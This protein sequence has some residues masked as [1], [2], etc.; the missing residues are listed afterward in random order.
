MQGFQISYT[1]AA[2]G[3]VIAANRYL[4]QTPLGDVS[5]QVNTYGKKDTLDLDART[6]ISI[7]EELERFD[8][9]AL[10][11]T[12]EKSSRVM[13]WSIASMNGFN[14]PV[15][16]VADPTDRSAP[17]KK[18][19]SAMPEQSRPVASAVG[20]PEIC[21]QWEKSFSSPAVV[22]GACSAVTCLMNGQPICTAI[23]NYITQDLFVACAAGIRLFKLEAE[24]TESITLD[25][26]LREGDKIEF[27]A[28]VDRNVEQMRRFVTFLGKDGYKE[29]FLQSKLMSEAD[30]SKH[31]V[32]DLPGGPL[33]ILYLSNLFAN[34]QPMGFVLANGEKIGEWIHWLTCVHF[35]SLEYDRSEPAL[36]L[37]EI[38]QEK[39]GMKDGISM[40]PS[41]AYSPLSLMP[42][43]SDEYLVDSVRLSCFENPSKVRATLMVA[44]RRNQEVRRLMEQHG[45]RRI[46]FPVGE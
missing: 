23:V 2:I 35:A 29:N 40:A 3:A 17:L 9:R 8:R 36:K 11:I 16:F 18:F 46:R 33:R 37:F 1:N 24:M 20:T 6:E 41:P 43:S 12:E 19:F 38:F 10:L 42:G 28:I 44:P 21:Q 34:D 5:Q 45:Y 4:L 32:Y 30:M 22:S 25:R 14:P 31:L 7:R 15:I 26:V 13:P 27:P 39:P